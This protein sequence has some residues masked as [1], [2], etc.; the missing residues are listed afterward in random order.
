MGKDNV[1][2]GR[3]DTIVDT[4]MTNNSV[5]KTFESVQMPKASAFRAKKG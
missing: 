2:T 5:G 1:F 3:M 4:G